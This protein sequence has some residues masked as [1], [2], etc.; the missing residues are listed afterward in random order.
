MNRVAW[1]GGMALICALT[2]QAAPPLVWSFDCNTEGFIVG[3][4]ESGDI[5]WNGTI[6]HTNDG[7]QGRLILTHNAPTQPELNPLTDFIEFRGSAVFSTADYDRIAMG[8]TVHEVPEWDTVPLVFVTWVDGDLVWHAGHTMP[9]GS[10]VVRVDPTNNANWDGG[11]T[12][13]I[14]F[15]IARTG[16][17]PPGFDHAAVWYEVDWIAAYTQAEDPDFVPTEQDTT[18]CDPEETWRNLIINRLDTPPVMDGVVTPAE[19]PTTPL[20]M[21]QALVD[22]FGSRSGGGSETDEDLSGVFY[23]GWDAT[24]LYCAAQVTDN[25]VVYNANQGERLN[26]T[27]SIQLITDHLYQRGGVVGTTDGLLIHDLAPGQLNDNNTAAYYQHWP[28]DD[29]SQTQ[30]ITDVANDIA[31][32]TV[33]GGYEVEMRIP[34]ANFTPTPITPAIGTLIGYV[35]ILLDF[36]VQGSGDLHDLVANSPALPWEGAGAAGWNTGILMGTEDDPDDDGLT[37]DEEAALGTDPMHWDTDRDGISD[38]DEVHVH[39][40]DP[41]DVDTD[42]DGVSDGAELRAGT[43]PLDPDDY[44]PLPATGVVALALLAALLTA[45][46]GALL[47]R[48]RRAR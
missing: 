42:G 6:A 18:D 30:T 41:L 36:E 25:V 22:A 11:N 28:G 45:C 21:T 35:A 47:L 34:W 23:L 9:G 1:V 24:Y 32:R 48:A 44:P 10:S 43:D 40:T 15:D 5:K 19:Y 37:N 39:G 3:V 17:L 26:G 29:G 27:D 20:P 4:G 46:A 16:T 13:M 7:G 8:I 31:G 33:A 12:N 2:A 14:R 38:Y